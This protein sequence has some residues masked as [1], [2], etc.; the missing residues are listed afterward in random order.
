VV[1]RSWHIS[2]K[3]GK[4]TVRS[5]NPSRPKE[6]GII[7]TSLGDVRVELEITVDTREP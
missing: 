2:A 3:K 4:G 7:M 5:Q 1:Y 6:T